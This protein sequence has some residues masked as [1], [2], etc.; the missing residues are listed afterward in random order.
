LSVTGIGKLIKTFTS[1]TYTV[2]ISASQA[3]GNSLSG[4]GI[5]NYGNNVTVNA[6]R[7][8][9]YSF[10]NWTENGT[11]ISISSTYSFIIN[12]NRNL[13]ANFTPFSYSI[14]AMAIPA[15]GGTLSG[16]GTYNFGSN[17][18]LNATP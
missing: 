16:S 6:T 2:S 7:R 1:D 3:D 5:Y 13:V 14:S 15:E 4:S 8:Q 10:A 17:I 9:G 11:Q 18:T 12:S